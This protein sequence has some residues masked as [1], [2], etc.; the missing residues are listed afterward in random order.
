RFSPADIQHYAETAP[1]SIDIQTDQEKIRLRNEI[2]TSGG[3]SYLLL[4]GA[5]L[6]PIEDTVDSFLEGL[7]WLIPTG[8]LLAAVASWFM[9]G[10]A[11]K[12]VAA[13]GRAASEIAVSNLDR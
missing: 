11:L 12:P 1:A 2:V 4:V 10:R 7:A 5:S 9:A 13:L 8:V 3:D 6:Q